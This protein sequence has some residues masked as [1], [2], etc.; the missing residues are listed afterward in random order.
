METMNVAYVALTGFTLWT[1][2]LTL[3]LVGIRGY[4]SNNGAKIALNNF[5][6]T[7]SDMPGFGQR[8]T[9]AHL[10]CLESLPVFASLVLVAGLTG[11][12][13]MME[14]TVMIV[15]YARL[16]QS[17]VHMISTSVPMVLIRALLFALQVLL[18][19]CYAWQ[20]LF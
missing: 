20:L 3:L 12:L 19:L 16:A 18:M 4:N 1:I 7:G 5:S 2:L 6:P 13:G 17:I 8:V 11:Q 9:R 10:N 15:L 14:S